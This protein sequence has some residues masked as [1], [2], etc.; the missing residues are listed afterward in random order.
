MHAQPN[1]HPDNGICVARGYGIKITVQRGHLIVH[2]GVGN[3]RRTRRFHRVTSKLHRLV[4]IGHTGYITLD[5]LR[6]L[7][8][9]GAALLQLDTNGK[10]IATSARSGPDLAG[11]R[12]AQSP[13]VD[14]P[15]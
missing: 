6:W 12:R 2:D 11:L 13:L 10:L 15:A 8:D 9:T 5:A 4:V 1:E 7:H 3:R 14:Q